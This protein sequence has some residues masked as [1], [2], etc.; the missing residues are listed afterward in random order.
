MNTTRCEQEV[1]YSVLQQRLGA[2]TLVKLIDDRLKP[3]VVLQ[4][5][6]KRVTGC[7]SWTPKT[8]WGKIPIFGRVPELR[9]DVAYVP[10]SIEEPL[11]QLDCSRVPL[12]IADDCG[13]AAA[14]YRLNRLSCFMGR[15]AQWLLH[16]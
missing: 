7:R 16:E 5:L 10:H 4:D 1:G 6:D 15:K 9:L 14:L 12:H 3:H 11:R 2:Q 8:M 13:N